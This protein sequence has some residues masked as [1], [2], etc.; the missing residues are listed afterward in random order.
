MHSH[1]AFFS[2]WKINTTISMEEER[3]GM[4]EEALQKYSAYMKQL[5]SDAGIAR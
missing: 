4:A 1:N 2:A 3:K 5:F